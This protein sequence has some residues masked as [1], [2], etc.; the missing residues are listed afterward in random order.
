MYMV[1]LGAD[2]DHAGDIGHADGRL[3]IA[4]MS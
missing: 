2:T 1:F 4:I 3:D